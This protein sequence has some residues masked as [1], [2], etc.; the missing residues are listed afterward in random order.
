MSSG[1]SNREKKKINSEAS[2][3]IAV[4]VITIIAVITIFTVIYINGK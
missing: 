1:Y 3:A 2:L 4:V